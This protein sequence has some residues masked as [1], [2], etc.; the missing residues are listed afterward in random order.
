MTKRYWDACTC[1]GLLRDEP[2]KVGAC[3]E[4]IDQAEAGEIQIVTSALTIAEVLWLKGHDRVPVE[5]REMVRNFFR[6]E[7]IVIHEVDRRVAEIAQDVVWDFNIKHKDAIHVATAVDMGADVLDTF[8]GP[9]LNLDGLVG[10]PALKISRPAPRGTLFTGALDGQ[11]GQ[12][13]A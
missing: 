1:L 10:N 13:D 11:P 9:L 5:D 6:N 7:Y 4:I 12:D 8:D 3:Q 2:D